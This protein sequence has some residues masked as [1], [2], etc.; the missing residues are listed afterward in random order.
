[1]Q[2]VV[3]AGGLATRLGRLTAHRPKILLPVG[4]RPFLDLL[5]DRLRR[6][7]VTSVHLCLGHHAEQVLDHL[8]GRKGGPPVTTSVEP[9]ALGTAGC[10]RHALPHLAERFLSI[11][12]DT[13]TPVRL[14]EVMA[15]LTQSGRPAL[16]AVLRN[17]DVLETSNVRIRDGL[18]VEYDKFAPPGT[19]EHV[20]YGVAA[21]ERGVVTGL[22]PDRPVDLAEIFGP[23]ITSGRL[24]AHEVNTRFWEIGSHRGYAELDARVRTAGVP[25]GSEPVPG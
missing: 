19:Y 14:D 23:L 12:G 3:I 15:T 18:V 8:A 24:A 21:L 25:D 11:F 1:M 20:D 2:V 22:E 9:A 16:M 17:R 7:N 13:Y 6:E 10:L 4:G 5:L